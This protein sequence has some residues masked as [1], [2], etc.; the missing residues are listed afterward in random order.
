MT[1]EELIGKFNSIKSV[2]YDKKILY[3]IMDELELKYKK[4]NCVKCLHDYYNIVKEELGLIESAAEV[5]DFN[6]NAEYIYLLDRTQ[7]WNS[8]L[9]NNDTPIDVIQ[10]FIKTHPK[11]YYKIKEDYETE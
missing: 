7:T 4:T 11:G 10:D 1:K 9:I 3:S 6:E 8:Y 2:K 5:S